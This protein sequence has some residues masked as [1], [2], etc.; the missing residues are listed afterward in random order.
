MLIGQ[1]LIGIVCTKQIY[2]GSGWFEN[3]A[4]CASFDISD[5]AVLL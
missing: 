5:P 1:K 3:S 4:V 2:K